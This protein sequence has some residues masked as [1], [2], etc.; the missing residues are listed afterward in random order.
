LENL[1]RSWN[2]PLEELMKLLGEPFHRGAEA[3]LYKFE[4]LGKEAVLKLRI[5]KAYRAQELDTYLR[6]ERT[7]TEAK[8]MVVAL[9]VGVKV[10]TPYYVDVDLGLIIMQY[11]R[12]SS[13]VA[14]LVDRDPASSRP[15]ARMM[16]RYAALLHEASVSHGDLTTSN[17]LLVEGRNLFLIDFGLSNLNAKLRDF[18]I[19]FHLFLRSLESTHPEHADTLYGE[20]TEGYAEVR[21][22]NA[23]KELED[24]VREIRLMGR[25]VEERRSVWRLAR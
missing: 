7:A 6:R 21:G 24:V 4:W 17:A 16:G 15:V 13:T 20:F 25:Y 9:E 8:A 10:P 14:E 3:F 22:R 5:P 23:V 1:G 19:D 12:G 11:L 2:T 18:A